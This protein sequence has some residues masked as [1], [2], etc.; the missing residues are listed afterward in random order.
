[1]SNMIRRLK[2]NDG[3]ILEEHA[4]LERE[5]MG[6]YKTML[7]EPDVSKEE[8]IQQVLV[9]VPTLVI[10]EHNASLMKPISMHEVEIAVKQMAEGKAPGPNGFTINFFNHCWDMLKNDDL[11]IIEEER[12]KQWVLP[13]FNSTHLTL[14]PKRGWS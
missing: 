3:T 4:D 8:F 13:S 2:T 7:T 10:E 14:I 11:D 12:K 5:L 9:H 1:M 6:L